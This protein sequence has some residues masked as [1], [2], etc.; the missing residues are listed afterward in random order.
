MI[1]DHLGDAYWAVGR[2]IEA[3]F[4][5]N[6]ALSFDPTEA[7]AERIRQKLDI[8]LDAALAAEGADPLEVANGDD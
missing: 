5:W 7:D 3:E 4:Q 2:V 1:N 8:G 6:R